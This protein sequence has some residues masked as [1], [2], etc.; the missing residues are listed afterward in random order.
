MNPQ[1][2]LSGQPSA[3]RGVDEALCIYKRNAVFREEYY[4]DVQLQ[5]STIFSTSSGEKSPS[6][7]ESSIITVSF[8]SIIL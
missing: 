2:P 4:T 8:F 3:A 7:I 5:S 1:T 6:Y